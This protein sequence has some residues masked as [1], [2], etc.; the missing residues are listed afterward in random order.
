MQ[1]PNKLAVAVAVLQ[2]TWRH[3]NP[4]HMPYGLPPVA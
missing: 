1:A 4:A 2:A 3:H